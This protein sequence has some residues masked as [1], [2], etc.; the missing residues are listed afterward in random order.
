MAERAIMGCDL[1]RESTHKLILDHE[2]VPW[3]LLD[4]ND[5]LARV[6]LLVH[7][8]SFAGAGLNSIT[9]RRMS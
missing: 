9:I 3:L 4:G 6:S 7:G 8:Y 1:H 5:V 2:V